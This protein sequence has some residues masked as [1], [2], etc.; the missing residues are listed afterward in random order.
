M[1]EAANI[2]EWRGAAS[3]GLARCPGALRRARHIQGVIIRGATTNLAV[4]IACTYATA[5]SKSSMRHA[6]DL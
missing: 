2:R 1:F 5:R 3:S 4:S 6:N